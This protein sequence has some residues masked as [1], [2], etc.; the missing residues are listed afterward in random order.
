MVFAILGLDHVVLRARD[1]AAMS[2]FYCEVLGCSVEKL[3]PA[4][5]LTQLRAGRTLI[6]LVDVAGPLGRQG[7]APPGS[8]G[9]NMDHFCLRIEPFD[10]PAV[11][12][13]LRRHGV[14]PGEV[15][16]R[17]GAEGN[18]PSLYLLDPEGNTVELK[19][20]PAA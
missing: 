9:R 8:E 2:R 7:G 14:E 3:Q 17:Y 10:G 6:D 20:P 11:A 5:G 1:V 15:V 13:H 19:G 18:G 4:I 16:Q 12:A